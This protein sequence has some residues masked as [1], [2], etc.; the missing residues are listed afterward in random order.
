MCGFADLET[1]D[2]HIFLV[3]KSSEDRFVRVSQYKIENANQNI[4]KQKKMCTI[5]NENLLL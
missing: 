5:F 3:F 4:K 1:F 2:R